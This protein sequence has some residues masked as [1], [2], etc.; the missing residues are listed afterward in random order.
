MLYS[1]FV[2][3][4][5]TN[6]GMHEITLPLTKDECH[7]T[8]EW[9]DMNFMLECG[10][11]APS[12][13][14]V[15]MHGI[16]STCSPCL[17][18]ISKLMNMWLM[19]APN[20]QMVGPTCGHPY[21]FGEDSGSGHPPPPPP[22]MTP[23]EAF[24]VA[25]ADAL[26][27]LMQ[28]QQRPPGNQYDQPREGKHEHFI[29]LKPP[30]FTKADEPLEADAWV[31]AIEAKFDVLT[32]PCSEARKASFAALQ[33]RGQACIWWDHY[34]MMQPAGH[35]ITWDEFKRAFKEHHIPKGMVER[36]LNELLALKQGSDSMYEYA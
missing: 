13:I 32:L 1:N 12:A 27:Y 23:M 19:H 6:V 10:A 35:V 34:K 31:R 15:A 21:S 16:L 25:Q 8:F 36:K 7:S 26:R 17:S 9:R 18:F 29:A 24:F 20:M 33:L 14:F 22:N 5:N 11:A 30:L 28:N 2:V 4:L 3:W